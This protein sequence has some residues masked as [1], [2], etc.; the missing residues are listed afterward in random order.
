M[1]SSSGPYLLRTLSCKGPLPRSG[2]PSLR[3][4]EC[5]RIAAATQ[6]RLITR[7]HDTQGAKRINWLA[8]RYVDI[9]LDVSQVKAWRCPNLG[10]DGGRAW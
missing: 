4:N 3:D 6:E 9:L 5:V 10:I 8:C 2:L 1:Q 7:A